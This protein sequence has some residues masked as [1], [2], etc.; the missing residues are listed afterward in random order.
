M[1]RRMDAA[2]TVEAC[3]ARLQGDE[4]AQKDPV[5]LTE[6][7]EALMGDGRLE[8]AYDVLVA[9]VELDPAGEQGAEKLFYLGQIIGGRDGVAMVERGLEGRKPSDATLP[10][11][12]SLI[13]IWMTDLCMEDEAEAQC[14]RW[15]A[16]ALELGPNSMEAHTAVGSIRISQQRNEEAVHELATAWECFKQEQERAVQ[17]GSTAYLVLFEPLVKLSQHWLTLVEP[18]RAAEAASA[19]LEI[20]STSTEA[21][22]LEA[23]SWLL[24]AK[25]TAYAAAL[26]EEQA[27]VGHDFQ[28]VPG[29]SVVETDAGAT[30]RSAAVAAWKNAQVSGDLQ[31]D[32]DVLLAE[33]GGPATRDELRDAREDYSDTE[34]DLLE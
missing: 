6:Y 24:E 5:V 1:H 15:G 34:L 21:A 25:R 12:L 4:G 14:E 16:V 8:E 27:A 22:Y 28:N 29:V 20:D 11:V 30:A 10:A 2:H 19:A 7:A 32:V 26:P 9:A 31:E 13:E 17:E 33:M 18:V 23:F 3:Q